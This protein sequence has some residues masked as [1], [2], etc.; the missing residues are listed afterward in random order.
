MDSKRLADEIQRKPFRGLRPR[1]DAPLPS[2]AIRR[3]HA[4]LP[5]GAIRPRLHARLALEDRQQGLIKLEH[6]QIAAGGVDR[7]VAA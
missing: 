7:A 4:P 1:L 6:D 2:G 3:L 5:S